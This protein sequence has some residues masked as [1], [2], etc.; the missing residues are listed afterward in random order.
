MHLLIEKKEISPCIVLANMFDLENDEAKHSGFF[1]EIEEDVKSECNKYGNVSHISADRHNNG[2]VYIKFEAPGGA[3]RAIN[4][5]QARYF[6]GKQISAE[7]ID[8]KEYKQK[9]PNSK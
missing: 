2:V 7:Y 3:Q 4:A 5:L 6:G 9:F 1:R 8:P